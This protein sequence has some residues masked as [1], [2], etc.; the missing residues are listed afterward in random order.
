MGRPATTK[1]KLKDGFWLE[2]RNKKAKSG[3][4]LWRATE[5]QML[6]TAESYKR[7]KDVIILGELKKGKWVDDS[8]H[9]RIF[10]SQADY[11]AQTSTEEELE[12]LGSEF[13]SS[14]DE[15]E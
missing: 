5:E 6:K 12:G 14:D 4:K 7:S 13:S 2:L 10:E 11:E 3:V 1:K 9:E 15:M 8:M